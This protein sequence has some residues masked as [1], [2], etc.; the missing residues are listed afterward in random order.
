MP[1]KTSKKPRQHGNRP[2]PILQ[3][4]DAGCAA[5]MARKPIPA[6][7]AEAIEVGQPKAMAWL[8]GYCARQLARAES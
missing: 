3:A 8:D 5:R 7:I 4:Y 1:A 2:S 6:A